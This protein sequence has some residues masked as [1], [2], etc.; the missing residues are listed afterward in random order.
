LLRSKSSVVV[1]VLKIN[2]IP[3]PT[4]ET[5]STSFPLGK[6]LFTVFGESDK[7]S[8]LFVPESRLLD[9]GWA[10]QFNVLRSFLA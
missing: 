5:V 6:A 1:S 9:R 4:N 10:K 2:A 3:V 7:D 8:I